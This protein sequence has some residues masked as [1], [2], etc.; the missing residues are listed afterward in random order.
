MIL[1]RIKLG[2]AVTF[3]EYL[4]RVVFLIFLP[5]ILI[6][7]KVA[8]FAS[9]CYLFPPQKSNAVVFFMSRS[10]IEREY[11]MGNQYSSRSNRLF[12]TL[13]ISTCYR[14]GAE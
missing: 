7:K 9:N 5:K 13:A 12:C 1:N 10:T 4:A 11:N 2:R 8:F 14:T 3:M 6:R